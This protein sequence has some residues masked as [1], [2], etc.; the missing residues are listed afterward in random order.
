MLDFLKSNYVL[1]LVF[2]AILVYFCFS[3][4]HL[5]FSFEKWSIVSRIIAVG[6]LF[7]LVVFS[8]FVAALNRSRKGL[9]R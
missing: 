7:V 9:K 2:M 6:S 3:F 8:M 4:I 1:E 5:S